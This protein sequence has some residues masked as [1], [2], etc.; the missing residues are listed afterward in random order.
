LTGLDLSLQK[1]S[2]LRNAAL[3]FLGIDLD[4]GVSCGSSLLGVIKL[5]FRIISQILCWRG[6]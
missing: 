2:W 4:R 1:E 3:W 5:L 6:G